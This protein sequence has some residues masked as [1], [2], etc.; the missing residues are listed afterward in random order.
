MKKTKAHHI[1][2]QFRQDAYNTLSHRKDSMFELMEAALVSSSPQTLVRLSLA[3]PFRRR[4]PSAPDALADGRLDIEQ[5]RSLVRTHLAQ[6]STAGRMVWAL[7]GTVWPRP[8]AITSPERTYGHRTSPGIPQSG[9]IPAWEYQWL[10]AVPQ[11]KGSWVLPLDVARRRPDS[12]TPTALAIS[13]LRSAL[14]LAK[15]RPVVTMDSGYDPVELAKANLDADLLVR[16]PKRRRFYRPPPSYS[17]RATGAG[18]GRRRKHGPVFQLRDS[19]TQGVPDRSASIDDPAHGLVQV[20]VWQGLHDQSAA[21]TPLT[22]VR[23]QVQRLPRSRKSPEPLWLVWI[24]DKLPADLLELWRWYCQRFTVEHGFRFLKQTLGWTSIRPR[25]PEAADRWSWLLAL[26]L[27]Q[28]WLARSLVA[29]QRMPWE[30][31]LPEERLTPGRIQRAFPG[32]LTALGT[33]TRPVRP[34][35]KSPGR[36]PGERPKPRE[37]YPVVRRLQKKPA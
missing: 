23:V 37:R 11:V 21:Q 5:C 29:D 20:A 6:Q 33:P 8:A 7:D 10:V 12:G 32:L 16:L 14:S 1:L 18:K 2:W 25:S 22:V 36:R 26:G 30:R 4:W 31:V 3:T 17:L 24:G 34:R 15:L 35:G 19:T 13:Q 9:I 28:L 27:W